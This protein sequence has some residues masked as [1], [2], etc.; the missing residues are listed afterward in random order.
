MSSEYQLTFSANS[1]AETGTYKLLEV[2]ADLSTWIEAQL[3]DPE[4][5]SSSQLCIKGSTTEDA[6]LC[7]ANQTYTLRAVSLSNSLLVVSAGSREDN[8]ADASSSAVDDLPPRVVIHDQLSDI[9]ELTQTIPKVHKLDSVLKGSTYSGEEDE[10]ESDRED[11]PVGLSYDQALQNVQASQGE[12][13]AILKRRRVLKLQGRLRPV[14]PAHLHTILELILTQLASLSLGGR[15]HDIPFDKLAGALDLE[16]QVPKTVSW[17]VMEWFGELTPGVEGNRWNMSVPGMVKQIGLGVLSPHKDKPIEQNTFL[18]AWKEAVGDTF[19]AAAALPLL[20][21]NYLTSKDTNTKY[22]SD[23]KTY[24]TYFPL[25]SLAMEPAARFQ[26]LF[27][28]RTRWKAD[29][30]TPF[31]DDIAVNSR[32]RDKLLLKFTR[33]TTDA[34]GAW[35]T[36]RAM[37]M[38]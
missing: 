1:L 27:L 30:I 28:T 4:T 29:E 14:A 21:G 38:G 13:D 35:Y 17:Q 25:D 22:A 9:L 10:D 24:L 23:R 19:E 5:A 32:E 15:T 34:E 31:L 3:Q 7:T 8:H 26:E 37:Y 12:L 36:G 20:S 33:S 2:P 16:H 18:K 6:V 11:E